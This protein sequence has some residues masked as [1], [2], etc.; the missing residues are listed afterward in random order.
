MT[1]R[2]ASPRDARHRGLFREPAQLT[3]EHCSLVGCPTTTLCATEPRSATH[4]SA[5]QRGPGQLGPHHTT[6]CRRMSRAGEHRRTASHRP[7]LHRPAT[8]RF[9]RHRGALRG[10]A[11][12][13]VDPSRSRRNMGHEGITPLPRKS[14]RVPRLG[15][16]SLVS[17]VTA[18]GKCCEHARGNQ[19]NNRH[20]TEGIA[21][22]VVHTWVKRDTSPHHPLES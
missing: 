12:Q 22:Q 15:D 16:A 21:V 7:A 19:S 6:C 13:L 14:D 1:H 9:A 2:V 3:T 10:S 11:T 4:R 5:T 20:T 17:L 8:R 18:S